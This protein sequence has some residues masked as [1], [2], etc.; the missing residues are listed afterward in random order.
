MGGQVKEWTGEK[1]NNR[2]IVK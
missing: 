1:V 2:W